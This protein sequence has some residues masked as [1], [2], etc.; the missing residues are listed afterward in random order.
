LAVFVLGE[1]I[2]LYEARVEDE[3]N[4]EHDAP[5]IIGLHVEDIDAGVVCFGVGFDFVFCK[6][7]SVVFE[8][9]D[10][11]RFHEDAKG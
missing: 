1:S 5:V 4:E 3:K 8:L 7:V 6:F 11:V 10:K 9:F 2:T